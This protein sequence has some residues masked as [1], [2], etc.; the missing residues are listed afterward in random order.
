MAALSKCGGRNWIQRKA[1]EH[2]QSS[3]KEANLI[4]AYDTKLWTV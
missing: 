3:S 1:L 2:F 4:D